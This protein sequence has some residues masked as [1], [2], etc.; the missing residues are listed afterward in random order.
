M[1]NWVRL[2]GSHGEG[3]GQILRSSLALSIITGRPMEIT[4]IRAKRT[5]SGLKQ[6]HLQAVRAAREI[7]DGEVQGDHVGSQKLVFVPGAARAGA[8]RFE[9]P[10]AGCA[11]LVLQTVYLPL[12][13]LDKPSEVT[14]TGGTHVKSAPCF[15]YLDEAWRPALDRIGFSLTLQLERC[16]FY[17]RGG[18]EL[19]CQIAPLSPMSDFSWTATGQIESITP[20]SVV[21]RLPESIAQRQANQALERLSAAELTELLEPAE[22]QERPAASPGTMLG[23]RCRFSTGWAFFFSLGERGKPA[24]RVADEACDQLL[25]FLQAGGPPVD[26][27]LADQLLLPL[28]VSAHKSHYDTSEIT[29][30]LRTNADV[31]GHFLERK[32]VIDGELGGP[33]AVIIE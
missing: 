12:A 19:R 18:G 5:P 21:G 14:V 16:G 2:D 32:I 29:Q 22:L 33:G 10:T 9:I 28:A 26:P 30:H 27:H 25:A 17:P 11:P 31:I 13:L 8:Y 20:L 23:L 6:Q 15:D 1:G 24:E 4:R 3:G 7:C